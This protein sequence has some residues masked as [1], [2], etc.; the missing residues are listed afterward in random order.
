[1]HACKRLIPCK[2]DADEFHGKK[3]IPAPMHV[4]SYSIGLSR[5]I[6]ADHTAEISSLT[7]PTHTHTHTLE[8]HIISILFWLKRTHTDTPHTYQIDVFGST[9]AG[10][11]RTTHANQLQETTH[12]VY[13]LVHSTHFSG[14]REA[15]R[16]RRRPLET[17]Y[18]S[19]SA[20]SNCANHM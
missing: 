12:E 2:A 15:R 18:S 20:P 9:V 16:R 14:V 1:M 7:G 17:E 11:L 3:K 5:K 6:H 13:I 4:I 10:K 8:M 19:A